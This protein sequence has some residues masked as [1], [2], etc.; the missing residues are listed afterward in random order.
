MPRYAM[1]LGTKGGA[2]PTSFNFCPTDMPPY[3]VKSIILTDAQWM[4]QPTLNVPSQPQYGIYSAQANGT[5]WVFN[6]PPTAGCY[7]M[8]IAPKTTDAA[9][10]R[11]P[12]Q[13][14]VQLVYDLNSRLQVIPYPSQN[15][16]GGYS[17]Q[18]R[19]SSDTGRPSRDILRLLHF[20]L[21]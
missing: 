11:N 6:D 20:G 15:P 7:Q 3:R 4:S 16:Y 9:S 13:I 21:F 2:G 10:T 18:P 5:A 12:N 17:S 14:S 1:I 19:P 8:T